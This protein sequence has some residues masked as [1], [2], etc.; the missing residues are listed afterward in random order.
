MENAERKRRKNRSKTA[1][2]AIMITEEIMMETAAAGTI[3]VT[4]KMT[5]AATEIIAAA[6]A[7]RTAAGITAAT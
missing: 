5:I 2:V 1:A 4:E 6:I 7:V 3:A